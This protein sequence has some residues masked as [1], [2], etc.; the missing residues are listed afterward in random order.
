MNKEIKKIR[1]EI[2]KM[3]TDNREKSMI[4]KDL[5]RLKNFFLGEPNK[6]REHTN[7]QQEKMKE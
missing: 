7:Y 1:T 5:K 6:E 4:P 2:N 3:K